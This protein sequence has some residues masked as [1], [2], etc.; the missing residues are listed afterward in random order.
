MRPPNITDLSTI[1]DDKGI[2][3]LE[4]AVSAIQVGNRHRRDDGDFNPLIASIKRLGL[5]QSITITP[6]GS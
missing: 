6:E 3:G 1:T 4:R 2:V 5:L